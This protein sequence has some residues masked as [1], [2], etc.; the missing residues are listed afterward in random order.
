MDTGKLLTKAWVEWMH[1]PGYIVDASVHWFVWLMENP[2]S[3]I[4][5]RGATRLQQ[6]D[7]IHII[8]DKGMDVHD[9]AYVIGF[10]MGNASCK[11]CDWRF[12]LFLWIARHLYPE[13]YKFDGHAEH[14]YHSG[15]DQGYKKFRRNIHKFNFPEDLTVEHARDMWGI[16]V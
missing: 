5:F 1:K 9:E 8:L 3:P 2:V 6:H 15:W 11:Q 7:Y 12:K 10:C 14:G 4:S 16:K 13:G